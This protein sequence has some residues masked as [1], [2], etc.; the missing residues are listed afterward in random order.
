MKTAIVQIPGLNRDNDMIKAITKII[1]QSPILVW[2]S[3]TDIP[4]VDL[5]V[6]PGGFSY[7][8]YLRCGAIAART[9]V[10]QAIKKKAQQGIKVMGICN[11]FQ[12]LVELNLLPG[13]LMR[14]CSLK[15]VC[16]QVLLEVVNSN[17]AFTKSYKMN[18]II[19]CPVAHHDGNYFIDAKGLAEI[20]KN[21]QIVF[22]YASGTNPNGSLHDIAGVI[23]RRGNVLGMMPHPENIIEKFHGGIDGR[24]LF[25]SLLT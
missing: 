17:T 2:Q 11:G 1:G 7:G 25:A 5:I 24:G 21:N 3:D 4:D 15:F 12:I 19:K 16:K 23:N 13:I 9:P 8:D 6:I 10:M 14:N 20:E 18:Q 22:R